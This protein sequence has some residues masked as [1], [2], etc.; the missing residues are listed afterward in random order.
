MV[1][2]LELAAHLREGILYRMLI[3]TGWKNRSNNE[4]ER[5]RSSKRGSESLR[6]LSIARLITRVCVPVTSFTDNMLMQ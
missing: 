4:V 5:D 3:L 1:W 6:C 2:G